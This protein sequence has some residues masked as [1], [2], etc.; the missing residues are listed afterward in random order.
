MKYST[1][2][3]QSYKEKNRGRP[4]KSETAPSATGIEP[5][6]PPLRKLVRRLL[7]LS[8]RFLLAL[9]SLVLVD[10]H[11]Q[12]KKKKSIKIRSIKQIQ[13]RLTRKYLKKGSTHHLLCTF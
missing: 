2:K 10:W 9:G 8:K 12:K 1:S 5:R 13:I 11:L 3:N 4:N 7:A 6:L